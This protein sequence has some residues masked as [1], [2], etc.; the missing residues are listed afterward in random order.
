LN[1]CYIDINIKMLEAYNVW[2]TLVLRVQYAKLMM[3]QPFSFIF[4]AALALT[5]IT[6]VKNE[7]QR[8]APCFYF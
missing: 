4:S 5:P 7:S 6:N 2:Y 8:S 1:D 3:L